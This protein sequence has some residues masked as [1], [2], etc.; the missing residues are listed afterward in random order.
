MQNL[1]GTS[2]RVRQAQQAARNRAQANQL[3]VMLELQ[4]DCYAGVWAHHA[5][6]SELRATG[7]PLLDDGDLEEGLQTAAAI[8]DDRLMRQ[9]GRAASPESFTHGTSEQRARW[10]SV[11]FQAGELGACDTFATGG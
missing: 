4:A 5:N 1:L 8:G 10:L 7:I 3:S 9:A 11:G 2:D 6:E